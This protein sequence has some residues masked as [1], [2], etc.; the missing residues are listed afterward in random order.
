MKKRI[1]LVVVTIIATYTYAQK[2][3]SDKDLYKHWSIELNIGQNRPIEPFSTGY[4]TSKPNTYFYFNGIEH[5]DFGGRYMFSNFFGLKADLAYDEIKNQAGSGSLDFNLKQYRLGIQGVMN[6]SRL[7]R[8]ESFTNRIGLLAH[9][10][11]QFSK[12]KPQIG[13]NQGVSED[14][15]GIML[16]L[17]PQYKITN[18][19]AIT[20]DFTYLN[21]LRQHFNWDGSYSE[22]TNNLT[23]SI[24]NTSL[25]LTFYIGDRNKTH[26]DW[27][28]SSVSTIDKE[29]RKK[30]ADI[31]TLMNDTDKDGV[32]D[33]LDFENNT[34]AGVAVDTR[35]RFIDSN[36][37]G[38]PDELERVPHKKEEPIVEKKDPSK[39]ILENGNLNINVF[40]NVNEDLP[41]TGSESNIHLLSQYLKNYPDAKI[42]L[43]GFADVRGGE[44][45]NI[46]L[47]KRRA[48]K[49]KNFLVSSGINENRMTI[50][51]E[52]V[53][54]TYPSSSKTGLDLARRVSVELI[55]E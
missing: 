35:G 8:F 19:L 17:T 32:P 22:A 14:N 24:Y 52:G 10:G 23:G 44:Q 40:Y 15:G 18:W 27:Y 28:I 34:P 6:L 20:G 39:T 31:E 16:G 1:I 2:E 13:I 55:K 38:V 26:A 29:A 5:Y 11:F 50:I 48:M 4:F 3:K 36:K 46:D 47:S 30:I 21:N 42:K 49:L 33:Y 53:D 9:G 41:N 51:A 45:H 25:G 37:N 54:T 12:L 43:T 7:L